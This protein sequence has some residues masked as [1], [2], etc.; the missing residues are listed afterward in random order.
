M[1]YTEIYSL[2][3]NEACRKEILIGRV[4][5]DEGLTPSAGIPYRIECVHCGTSVC[6][7]LR[8]TSESRDARSSDR[9][10]TKVSIVIIASPFPSY[11]LRESPVS[12]FPP[13]NAVWGV[14]RGDQPPPASEYG[15][16]PLNS[17]RSTRPTARGPVSI[18]M[19]V[20]C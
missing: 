8:R 4:P 12:D 1:S 7:T 3:V 5:N 16:T 20:T 13:F 14:P 11:L 10:P 9:I 2:C 15:P 17:L 19:R 6:K 18:N